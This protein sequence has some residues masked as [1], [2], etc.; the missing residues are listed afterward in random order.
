[1]SK[2]KEYKEMYNELNWKEQLSYYSD[3]FWL[4]FDAMPKSSVVVDYYLK[5]KYPV[6]I[7]ISSEDESKYMK[8][9]DCGK[10]KLVLQ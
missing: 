7:T 10:V 1:M 8:I 9:Y 6:P 3:F 2:S 5:N 4:F